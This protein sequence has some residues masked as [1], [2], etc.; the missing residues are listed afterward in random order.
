[1]SI[2]NRHKLITILP[3]G[4]IR[5]S[6]E[7]KEKKDIKKKDNLCQNKLKKKKKNKIQNSACFK[8]KKRSMYVTL[9][10]RLKKLPPSKNPPVGQYNPNLNSIYK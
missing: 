8:I 1:M 7:I 10:V 5:Q 2:V 4:A 9:S 6:E 3:N